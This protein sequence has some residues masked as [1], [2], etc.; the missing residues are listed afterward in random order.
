MQRNKIF[1]ER[2]SETHKLL[3][4]RC[5]WTLLVQPGSKGNRIENA[6]RPL[7]FGRVSSVSKELRTYFKVEWS[8]NAAGVFASRLLKKNSVGIRSQLAGVG[9]EDWY[10]VCSVNCHNNSS[11]RNHPSG[12]LVFSRVGNSSVPLQLVSR[13]SNVINVH[14]LSEEK[15][16]F[17]DR[18]RPILPKAINFVENFSKHISIFRKIFLR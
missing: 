2:N 9:G 17:P 18:K 3:W 1:H 12:H 8:L 11:R 7:L 5:N 15:R 10:F 16:E 6:A 14:V 13:Y 4:A